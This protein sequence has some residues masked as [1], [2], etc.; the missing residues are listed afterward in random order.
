MTEA[1]TPLA[2]PPLLLS[3]AVTGH[4]VLG[5]RDDTKLMAQI[6]GVLQSIEATLIHKAAGSAQDKARPVTLR[7]LC[8]LAAGADQLV[9]RTMIEAQGAHTA[10]A[11]LS[12][13]WKLQV[14][15]PFVKSAYQ[16]QL[17]HGL[18][19]AAAAQAQ[20]QFDVLTAMSEAT[21]ELADWSPATGRI[22]IGSADLADYWR[23]RRYRTLGQLLVRQADLLIALWRGT[24]PAGTGGTADVVA[25]AMRMGVPILWLNPETGRVISVTEQT[26]MQDPLT[27]AAQAACL[28]VT[29]SETS[30]AAAIAAAVAALLT[31]DETSA[32]DGHESAAE[33]AAKSLPAFLA[34]E[35]LKRK[36]RAVFYAWLTWLGA[37][38]RTR[39]DG[40]P[41]PLVRWPGW[42]LKTD[43]LKGS[44]WL[45]DSDWQVSPPAAF[46]ATDRVVA[47]YA[48]AADTVA[49]RMGHIYR[50]AYLGLFLAAALAV[51]TGLFSLFM[52]QNHKSIFVAAELAIIVAGIW[53]YVRSKRHAWH[54][55]WLNG[56]HLVESL[57]GG[58]MLAWLGFGGRRITS[59]GAPWSAWLANAV[60]ALP[61]V[62]QLTL[63]V[64]AL[65]AIASAMDKS[66]AGQI[67]YHQSNERKLKALHHRLDIAGRVLVG[68][69]VAVALGFLIL[70][71]VDHWLI[72]NEAVVKFARTF[73]TFCGGA[74]PAL[75]AALAGIRFQG[76]FERFALRSGKTHA[77]LLRLATQIEAFKQRA[78]A[79][80]PD[81]TASQ[82][83]YEELLQLALAV[84]TVFENDL[85]D[86]RFVYATRHSPEP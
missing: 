56:R 29:R 61:G 64:R 78:V 73:T 65:A 67:R 10:L 47:P 28:D 59:A 37:L 63:D 80:Q 27:L 5:D 49:T 22:G 25:D 36:S 53:L 17:T 68:L 50:S 72:L 30:G 14:I 71:L 39:G 82:P 19:A 2:M 8:G 86:W 35:P 18:G 11:K 48:L 42:W 77:Q 55:R 83:L 58:R 75:A 62:P 45:Q 20:S 33:A 7:L 85:E 52:G 12:A 31:P 40:S 16:A 69:A 34:R 84:Q 23:D 43:Y 6:A 74:L 70:R 41:E 32:A 79:D 51:A 38:G 26:L 4:R 1:L 81:G 57:R 3:V 60:M 9:A 15:I 13:R 21:L 66:V 54:A 76:D 44:G 46:L 24:A